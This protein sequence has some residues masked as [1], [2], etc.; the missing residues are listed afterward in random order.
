MKKLT[1][2]TSGIIFTAKLMAL[3]SDVIEHG[4]FKAKVNFFHNIFPTK[5]AKK[6]ITDVKVGSKGEI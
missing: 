1:L 6:D 5:P 2:I 4:I 3:Y